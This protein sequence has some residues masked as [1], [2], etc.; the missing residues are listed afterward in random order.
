MKKRVAAAL[1]L[2]LGAS[3]ITS[4]CTG[5][6][7]SNGAA[8]KNLTLGVIAEPISWDPAQANDGHMLQ[9]YQAVY[10]NLIMRAP[11]GTLKPML[12]TEWKYLDEARTQLQLK[13]KSGVT[14][15]DG[16]PFDANAVKANLEHFKVANGPQAGQLRSLDSVTV[17]DPSTVTIKLKQADPAF[18]YYLSQAAGLM[19][20]PASFSSDAL[21]TQPV[22]SGPYE[23]VAAESVAGQAAVYKK[24]AGYWNADLQKWDQI[25]M[26]L[27][28][29]NSARVNALAA[30]QVDATLVD[31][32]SADQVKSAGLTLTATDAGWSG[33]IL[34]DRDG[35]KAAPLKDVRVRQ[36]MNH[37]INREAL[38]KDVMRGSGEVTAQV[39]G[40]ASGSHLPELDSR[41][42]YDPAKAKAL[43]AEA[44]FPDGVDLVLSRTPAN[45]VAA[46][47]VKSQFA[48]VGIRL[49][50]ESVT[51]DKYYSQLGQGNFPI[52]LV[53]LSQGPTWVATNQLVSQQTIYNAFKTTT[54]ELEA[55]INATRA[56]GPQAGETGK[57]INR[58]LT[59][60]AWFVPFY[61]A[62]VPYAY[63]ATKVKV[64]P[65]AASA[66]P[67]IYN[68]EP[69]A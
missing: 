50:I 36:A 43:L 25:T 8:T 9:P 29:D 21:K 3:V 58:Y 62:K 48:E 65:Q 39:F 46:N 11:D 40:K 6:A 60:N 41:Y 1:A 2:A 20:S 69:V 33:L 4:G 54:P 53:T 23:R 59:D 30:K 37:A 68:Y 10:D 52:A 42:P 27:L 56:A 67:L 64:T 51:A 31:P 47:Y 24:R 32:T 17:D 63:D 26:R 28:T 45:E 44:G 5:P 35:K 19:G 15:S 66:V 7:G 38:L 12:A 18:E 16:T 49:T 22:G 57:A 34:L 55:A 14:F 13:L 61:V